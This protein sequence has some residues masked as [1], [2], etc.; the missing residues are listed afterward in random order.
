MTRD[1]ITA[2]V[3][4]VVRE[5]LGHGV[6]PEFLFSSMS[7]DSLDRVHLI[8]E[9]ENQFSIDISDEEIGKLACSRDVVDL[10]E[11]KKNERASVKPIVSPQAAPPDSRAGE[12]AEKDPRAFPTK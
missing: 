7:L 6:S 2:G 8:V 9:I 1:E 11:R 12:A 3:M 4:A 10:V 5:E